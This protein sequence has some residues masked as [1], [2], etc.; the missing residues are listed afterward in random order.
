MHQHRSCNKP[1]PIHIIVAKCERITTVLESSNKFNSKPEL[2]HVIAPEAPTGYVP[3]PEN[4]DKTPNKK[5]SLRNKLIGAGVVATLAV[6]GGIIGINAANHGEKPAEVPSTS[7]PVEEEPVA[8]VDEEPSTPE[9]P[10][11]LAAG[12]EN[13]VQYNLFETLTADQQAEIKRMESLSVEEFRTLVYEDQYKFARF[14]YDNNLDV[15]KFR[16]DNAGNSYVYENANTT[17]PVGIVAGGAL[18]TALMSS[19]KTV[20]S[21][22]I[23]FDSTTARK[24]AS[25][26]VESPDEIFFN[27]VDALIASWNVNTPPVIPAS[28]V[29]MSIINKDGNYMI[30]SVDN[31]T[32]QLSQSTVKIAEMQKI[33]GETVVDALTILTVLETDPRFV[34]NLG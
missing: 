26:L 4:N 9:T 22:G 21:D 23:T 7:A 8:P 29:K 25:M 31:F 16:L 1:K 34:N 19:L 18:E 6:S 33:N 5:K 3:S 32:G 2:R 10:L 28:E 12:T 13:V 14:V 17:T 24:V 15:L 20:D 27:N 30:N 11:D